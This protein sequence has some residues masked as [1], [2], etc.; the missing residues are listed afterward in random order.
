MPL[1]VRQHAE[2][3]HLTIADLAQPSRP[4]PRDADR[5]VPLSGKAAFVDDPGAGRLPPQ[6]SIDV[7]TDLRHHGFV[8]P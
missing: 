6:K 5:A 4:L 2:H 7:A 3:R 8:I 1:A